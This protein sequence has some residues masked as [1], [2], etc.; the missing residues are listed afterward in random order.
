MIPIGGGKY[1]ANPAL[2]TSWPETFAA[3]GVTAELVA[4]KF[5][6]SRAEQDLFAAEST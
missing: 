6:I 1:S 3:M 2:M 4:Q 5:D